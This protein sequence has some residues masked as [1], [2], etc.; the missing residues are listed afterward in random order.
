MIPPLFWIVEIGAACAFAAAA[1]I[2]AR[3]CG[4]ALNFR[5]RK[6]AALLAGGVSAGVAVFAGHPRLDDAIAF[7]VVAAA[8]AVCAAS[9]AASGFV[10]DA[11]TIPAFTMLLVAAGVNGRLAS[12][13]AGAASA[14]GVI[15]AIYAATRGRGI[16][17]G[18]AKLAACIGAAL[19]VRASLC[20]LGI[21]FVAGALCGVAALL[22]RRIDRRAEIRFAPYLAAGTIAAV[23]WQTA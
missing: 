20:A 1:R 8:G 15:V 3:R 13:I 5:D 17:L 4:V 12:S 2:S 7:A 10:F 19:G 21:A 22:F 9:D 11:V 6:A 23:L 18:D 14:C 16:G